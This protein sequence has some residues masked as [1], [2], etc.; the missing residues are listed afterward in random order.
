MERRGQGFSRMIVCVTFLEGRMIPEGL[1]HKFSIGNGHTGE[2][3]PKSESQ[4]QKLWKDLRFCMSFWPG[5]SCARVTKSCQWRFWGPLAATKYMFWGCFEES[6]FFTK[7]DCAAYVFLPIK[8][9][10]LFW[11]SRLDHRHKQ[12]HPKYIPN[13][14]KGAAVCFDRRC[15]YSHTHNLLTFQDLFQ[16]SPYMIVL[17]DNHDNHVCTIFNDSGKNYPYLP[18]ICFGYLV[19]VR[20]ACDSSMPGMP[21][22]SMQETIIQYNTI[23]Y[24]TIQYNTTQ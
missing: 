17:V 9:E 5:Y 22:W 13:V 20:K 2:V 8:I 1:L 24:N 23:Q 12:R 4:M 7:L 6:I 3:V 16:A 14:P 15:R 18:D 21:H 19:R 10:T 11:P